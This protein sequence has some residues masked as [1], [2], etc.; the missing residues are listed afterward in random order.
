MQIIWKSCVTLNYDFC[1][2]ATFKKDETLTSHGKKTTKKKKK[3]QQKKTLPYAVFVS[4]DKSCS[5]LLFSINN[6]HALD[7]IKGIHYKNL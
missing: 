6:L 5:I 3:K 7:S 2:N 4:Y 1:N